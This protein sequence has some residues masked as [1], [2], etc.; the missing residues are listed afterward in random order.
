MATAQIEEIVVS[1]RRKEESLQDVPIAVS[2]IT[3]EQIQRQGI[4]DLKD[5]VASQP[6]VQ[7]DQSY[8]PSDNRITIR[9]LSNTRGRS[10]VAFLVDGIDVTTENLISAGSGLL[11]NRR[12]LTDVER[13]EIV[14]GPQSAL[15]WSRRPSPAPS[16][17]S[18]RIPT[19]EFEGRVGI[20]MGDYGNRTID[21]VLGGPIS[22]TVGF[23]VTGVKFNEDGYYTNSHHRQKRRWFR[24]LR[25]RT[26]LAVEAG[27]RD[28]GQGTRLEYSEENYDPRAVVNIQ[29][30]KA[31]NIPT[32][33]G[34]SAKADRPAVH[35]RRP[36]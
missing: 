34:A 36:D 8:G 9:G 26:N 2:A 1:T 28:Q 29:G 21:G 22:D 32:Q 19:E 33:E 15:L 27:R 10:N 6:S 7:F 4:T 31:Y 11:A 30:D 16:A 3:G 25:R 17:T 35:H 18:P 5:I 20:D 12:L 14:K 23:R 13:I 24:R